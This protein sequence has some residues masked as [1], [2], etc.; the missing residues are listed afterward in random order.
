MNQSD[1]IKNIEGVGSVHLIEPLTTQNYLTNDLLPTDITINPD[2]VDQALQRESF[3]SNLRSI[4]HKKS[5]QQEVTSEE[6]LSLYTQLADF[7]EL[8][9]NNSRI[10]LYFPY[11]LFEHELFNLQTRLKEL[12][13]IGFIRLLHES[14]IRA[15]FVDGDVL[16][17][18]LGIPERVRKIAHLI[19]IF[20]KLTIIKPELLIEL[21]EISQ[22][23]ELIKSIL[24]GMLTASY[25]GILDDVYIDLITEMSSRKPIIGMLF[26][27][28]L[29]ENITSQLPQLEVPKTLE[30]I[31]KHL[32]FDLISLENKYDL[33]SDYART[34]SRAR[35]KWEKQVSREQIINSAVNEI[36]SQ[37]LSTN[38]DL[39][40]IA[41]MEGFDNVFLIVAIKSIF[42]AAERI[43][44]LNLE[45][46]KGLFQTYRVI[47]ENSFQNAQGEVRDAIITGLNYL[48]RLNVVPKEYLTNLGLQLTDLSQAQ[49]VS[50]EQLINKDFKLLAIV[51][52]RIEQ[53]YELSKYVYP[54]VIGF[55]SRLKGYAGTNSDIDM[56]IFFK[57]ETPWE[58]RS[59]IMDLLR[60][61]IPEI[62]GIDKILEFW[63]YKH[64][65]I[66]GFRDVPREENILGPLEVHILMNSLWIGGCPELRDIYSNIISKY[67]NL[68][69]FGVEEPQIRTQF[70]RQLEM[71]IL[72]CR[73]MHKG[74]K[75][76]YPGAKQ[77][78]TEHSNLIDYSGTFWDEGYRGIAT[79]L[80]LE[81]IFLPAVN[82]GLPGT[83][84]TN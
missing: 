10:L 37:L 70:L 81:K 2:L 11:S 76:F 78:Q 79:L 36:A 48:V 6:L 66:Y 32:E 31:I 47:I 82:I 38:L 9:T 1:L 39:Q 68:N 43:S 61:T 57:P 4:L 52:K 20:L 54:F 22:E 34:I 71:D 7:L 16:E 21:L 23:E 3:S 44:Y 51:A 50:S 62:N 35:A 24:E 83:D 63:L 53:S 30:E 56:A 49:A 59:E 73:L 69:R 41:L 25:S 17:P 74:Y 15:N 67:F 13:E 65:G 77:V 58:K 33:N 28:L 12:I 27:S 8:D 60:Q 75:R 64:N 26:R 29:G 40:S 46:A 45:D 18:G 14:D 19:P 55:G 42:T 72:Q 84:N 5:L 80:F